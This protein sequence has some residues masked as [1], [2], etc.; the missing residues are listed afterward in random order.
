MFRK[1]KKFEPDYERDENIFDYTDFMLIDGTSLPA[2][3]DSQLWL[4]KLSIL[5]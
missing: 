5:V 2:I 1:G 3:F 4:I